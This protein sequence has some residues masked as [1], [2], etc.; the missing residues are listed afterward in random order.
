[1]RR[2]FLN[3]L[4]ICLI[5]QPVAAVL[6]QSGA[7]KEAIQQ[8]QTPDATLKNEDVLSM[9]KAGLS[10]EEIIAKIKASRTEFEVSQPKLVELREAAIPD[11]VILAM[12]EALQTQ[13]AVLVAPIRKELRIPDGTKIEIESAFDVSSLHFKSGQEISFRVV[14]PIIV[15]G[16]TL[17][18]QGAT[19]T[20]KIERS[21][22]GGHWGKAGLLTW[23][24]ESVTAS[25]GKQLPLRI[26]P[27][28]L[29][30]DSKGA[31]VAT[32][33]IITGALVP[34][35]A[36]VA[37]LHGFKR[38]GDAFIPAGQ[39]YEVYI[40]GDASIKGIVR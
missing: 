32:S 38:G 34:L 31:K 29:R 27:M 28:R 37:L 13:Q 39:R 30:G 26:E 19:A 6:A 25:D 35:I 33:M 22:R 20:G 11:A 3:F 2:Y 12:V 1:M 4:A 23:K 14:N 40:Q 7:A 9:N 5:A 24:M 21:K 17:V 15:E 16:V 18:E 10:P 36:P 8:T